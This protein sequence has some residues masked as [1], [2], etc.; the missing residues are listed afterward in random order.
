MAKKR[1]VAKAEKKATK[2]E[3]AEGKESVRSILCDLFSRDPI[4]TAKEIISELSKR[5]GRPALSVETLRLY[6]QRYHSGKLSGGKIPK[7]KCPPLQ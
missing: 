2:E 1:A 7:V 6:R 4:G 5:S 3:K